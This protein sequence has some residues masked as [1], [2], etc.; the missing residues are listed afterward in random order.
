MTNLTELQEVEELIM[1]S[2]P[3][4]IIHCAAL[5][6]GIKANMDGGRRFYEENTL[7]DNN[8]LE[9]AR[10]MEIKNL[11]Y[12]GSSCMYPANLDR[13]MTLQDLN[14]G[15]LEP[16]NYHYAKAKLESTQKVEIIAS[17]YGFNWRTFIS[18][19]LYGPFDNFDSQRSHLIASIISK[20][21]RCRDKQDSSIVVWGSGKPKREFTFV[22]DFAEWIVNSLEFLKLLPITVNVGS[23]ID[24]TVEEY[25]KIV[26]KL[27]NYNV[28]L[29]FDSNYPD[30]VQRKL[31]DSSVA[32]SFGW[33]AHTDIFTGLKKTIDWYVQNEQ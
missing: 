21:I 5:V 3:T 28:T 16:T 8:I 6:G 23:G 9:A 32:R 25:Y 19:N 2:K 22:E 4:S 13:I 11:V 26:L 10:K 17:K 24:Y 30:G 18:S 27:L 33:K 7:I 12:I 29:R 14:T 15:S 1:K 31:M 20:A